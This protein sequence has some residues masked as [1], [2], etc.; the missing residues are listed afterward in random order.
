M[1]ECCVACCGVARSPIA[2]SVERL[3]VSSS[4][5]RPKQARIVELPEVQD[6]V[7]R[8][9]TSGSVTAAD[10]RRACAAADLPMKE[11]R[12]VAEHLELLGVTV[13]PGDVAPR[14]RR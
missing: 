13:E 5:S 7:T 9:R 8:G 6:L 12:V 11:S 1:S 10:V 4:S 14:R 2:K 3:F